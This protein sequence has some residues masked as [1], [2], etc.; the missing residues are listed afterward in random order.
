VFQALR[1]AVND[2]VCCARCSRTLP[3]PNPRKACGN[4]FSQPGRPW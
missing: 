4:H 3:Q 1:I 2:P